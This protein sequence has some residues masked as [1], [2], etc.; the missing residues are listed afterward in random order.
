MKGYEIRVYRDGS[1]RF[2]S[3][4]QSRDVAVDEA[5][6]LDYSQR[7]TG[8]SVVEEDQDPYT[9]E[10]VS[11]TIFRDEAFER[12]VRER[13]AQSRQNRELRQSLDRSKK[14]SLQRR[15]VKRQNKRVRRE[16]VRAGALFVAIGLAGI[17]AMAGLQELRDV[18]WRHL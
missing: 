11:R 16:L 12:G 1:W 5:R 18:L 13:L 17:A 10:I 8:V 14:A 3:S 4:F 15:L 7:Y 9:N 2:H 6:R